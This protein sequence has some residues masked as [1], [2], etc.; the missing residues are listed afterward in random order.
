ML[1]SGRTHSSRVTPSSGA[2]SA[3]N[4]PASQAAA[5]LRCEDTAKASICSRPIDH[6]AAMSS[7]LMPCG[8]SPSG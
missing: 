3:S 1:V 6:L 8:T 5:A 4:S 7:A 2:T